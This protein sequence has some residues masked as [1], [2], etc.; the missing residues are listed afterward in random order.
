MPKLKLSVFLYTAALNK[1]Y[2]TYF[3]GIKLIIWLLLIGYYTNATAKYE[4][5]KEIEF[6]NECRKER[7]LAFY[8][9]SIENIFIILFFHKTIS[10]RAHI[11][12]DNLPVLIC[13]VSCRW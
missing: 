8:L 13:K 10:T 2:F 7:K 3:C 12:G 5:Y 11:A 9:F 4:I 1:A 6:M